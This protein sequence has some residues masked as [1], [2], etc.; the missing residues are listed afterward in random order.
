ME[1]ENYYQYGRKSHSHDKNALKKYVVLYNEKFLKS[2]SDVK[3][4]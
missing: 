2:Q 4:Y 1:I 3:S